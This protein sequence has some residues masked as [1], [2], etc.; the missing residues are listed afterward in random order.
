MKASL[1]AA[2]SHAS[3]FF[4][5]KSGLSIPNSWYTSLPAY[6]SFSRASHVLLSVE[7]LHFFI[8]YFVAVCTLLRISTSVKRRII[9]ERKPN[10]SIKKFLRVT[11]SFSLQ[12]LIRNGKTTCYMCRHFSWLPC[13]FC[14]TILNFVL[15]S[16]GS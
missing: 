3:I 10:Y 14:C 8:L 9:A 4:P 7:D 15:F 1:F 2:L 5:F 13:H 16:L 11:F 12:K 6:P